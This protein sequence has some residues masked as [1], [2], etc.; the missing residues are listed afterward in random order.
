[1]CVCF[2][3][4]VRACVCV[5]GNN[6]CL[7]LQGF[8]SRVCVCVLSNVCLLLQ[9]FLYICEV[10]HFCSEVLRGHVRSLEALYCPPECLVVCSPA[11]LLLVGHLHECGSLLHRT[12]LA[13]CLGQAAGALAGRSK[14][15][16]GQMVLKSGVDLSTFC[17]SCR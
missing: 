4:C 12:F 1:M 8:L 10:R 3:V 9:G 13:S 11:W 5:L 14:H 15:S 6:V 16:A 2:F 7:L 17:T